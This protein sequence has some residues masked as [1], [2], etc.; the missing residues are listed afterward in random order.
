MSLV[1]SGT[2]GVSD[3]DGSAATPA[4]RGTDTNTGI[5]FPAADTIAFAE[6]GVEAARFDPNGNLGLKVTPS[7]SWQSGRAAMQIGPAMS[8]DCGNSSQAL[9]SANRVFTGS[10]DLYINSANAT[11]Y[12]QLNG[13]HAW[14]TAPSGTAGNAISFTQAMTLDASGNL[15]VGTSSPTYRLHVANGYV[16]ILRA[17]GYGASASIGIDLGASNSDSV[18]NSATYAWGQEVIGNESGQSLIFKAYRRNDTTVERA[19]IDSSG[20]LLVGTTSVFA[21]ARLTVE[22]TNSRQL[23]LVHNNSTG[24]AILSNGVAAASTNWS[25][26]SGVSSNNTVSNVVILGNGDIRNANN[27]YGALSD[28]KLKENVTDVTPKLDKLCQVR[29]VN[30]NLKGDYEQH[31]QLGV[32]AQELEQIFP[33]MVEEAPDRDAEGNILETTTKS[34]KYSVFVPMLIKAIQEQQALIQTLTARVAA[35]EGAQQ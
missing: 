24:N 10:Q 6:G 7:A 23:G 13:A 4:I 32:I 21:S 28:A 22:S 29:V 17:T 12:Q 11:A 27:V 2:V 30:Y 18:N 5:F 15:G 8:F 19:R 31:K 1:L 35:L 9:V 33:G 25:H 34:V 3:V 26:F 16:G 20:N 14:F